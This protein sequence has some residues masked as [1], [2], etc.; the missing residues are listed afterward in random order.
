LSFLNTDW[1]LGAI[2]Q[3]SGTAEE[4]YRE[5]VRDG[6]ASRQWEEL[7]GQIYAGSEAFNENLA[8]NPALSRLP[9]HD[10]VEESGRVHMDDVA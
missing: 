6:V 4:Q 9:R 7:K 10:M 5:F 3:K 2:Q 8:P 1:M